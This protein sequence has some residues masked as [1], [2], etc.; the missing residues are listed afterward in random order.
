MKILWGGRLEK[1]GRRHSEN[2]AIKRGISLA[3]IQQT[4]AQA[5]VVVIQSE[6]CNRYYKTFDKCLCVVAV[7]KIMNRHEV[8]TCFWEGPDEHSL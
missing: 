7:T 1:N 4:I 6:D 3:M 2:R 5:E 8:I